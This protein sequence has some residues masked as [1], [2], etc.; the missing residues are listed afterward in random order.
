M[1][2][3][4]NTNWY[5]KKGLRWHGS[6]STY[7]IYNLDDAD[8]K[9]V[10]MKNFYLDHICSNSTEQTAYEVWCILKLVCKRVGTL[11]PNM[12]YVIIEFDNAET[13]ENNMF[14]VL[15]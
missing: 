9:R 11:L 2:W 3:E 14:P 13:N 7:S 8:T 1:F 6:A 12:K 15:A 10:N 4:K 5:R